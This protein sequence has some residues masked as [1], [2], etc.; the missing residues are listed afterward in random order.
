MGMHGNGGPH[1]GSEWV[2]DGNPAT[3]NYVL[4]SCTVGAT[5]SYGV[6]GLIG[7]HNA[8][9]LVTKC[10]KQSALRLAHCFSSSPLDTQTPGRSKLES[11]SDRVLRRNHGGVDWR[12]VLWHLRCAPVLSQ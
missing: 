10:V 4:L 1:K 9:R 11:L 12:A 7:G 3:S 8:S 2:V 5:A 6:G